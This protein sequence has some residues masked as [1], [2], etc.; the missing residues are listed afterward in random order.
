ME[1]NKFPA[2]VN[3]Y[4]HDWQAIWSVPAWG[5]VAVLVVFLLFFRGPV[6]SVVDVAEE[7]VLVAADDTVV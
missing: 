2:P 4:V 3:G 5:A 6:K 1:A 7:E